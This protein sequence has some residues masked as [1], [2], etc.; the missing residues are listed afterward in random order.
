MGKTMHS[1][2]TQVRNGR[3]TSEAATFGQPRVI[4]GEEARRLHAFLTRPARTLTPA[5]E[6]AVETYKRLMAEPRSK[7]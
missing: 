4:E 5:M 6:R 1:E 7:P 3:S 2:K